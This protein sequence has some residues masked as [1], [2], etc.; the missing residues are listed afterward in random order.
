VLAIAA[1][2]GASY[3]VG[4]VLGLALR[5]P[6]STPSVLWPPNAILTAALLL[7]P[8]RHWLV[9][10]LAALPPHLLTESGTEDW[11]FRMI[12]GFYVTNCSQAVISAIGMRLFSHAPDR[13]DTTRQFAIFVSAV[14]IAAPLLSSFADAAV[15]HWWRGDPYWPVWQARTFSS[16]LGAVALTPAILAI[17]TDA[18]KFV[19]ESP[20]RP[21]VEA[22]LIGFAL[23]I[24]GALLLGHP[25][26][27]NWLNVISERQPL[28]LLLPI[29]VWATL[30]FGSHGASLTLFLSTL[31]MVTMAAKAR[32]PFAAVSGNSAV[33][34]LQLSLISVSIPLLGLAVVI[35]ER[36]EAQRTLS[37]QLSFEQMLSR[38]SREFVRLPSE[39]MESALG[40]WLKHLGEFLRIERVVLFRVAD[41]SRE[42]DR[43]AEWV[44]PGLTPSTE[45][46]PSRDFPWTVDRVLSG[47]TVVLG[48]RR[49][50]PAEAAIDAASCATYGC[51]SLV[52]LPLMAGSKVVGAMAF[53]SVRSTVA[54]SDAAVGRLQLVAEVFANALTRKRKD[55]A[56]RGTKLVHGAILSSITAGVAVVSREGRVLLINNTWN[57]STGD[58]GLPGQPAEIGAVFLQ[59]YREAA[60]RG[61]PA[62]REIVAGIEAVLAGASPRF[63]HQYTSPDGRWSV[64]TARP[65]NR[66][67]GG[68]VLTHND[69][70]ERKRAELD[71]QRVR[72]ELA[73]FTRVSTMGELTA[74]LAHQLN[75]PLTGILSNAQA[76]V[77]LLDRQPAET[78]EVRAILTDIIADDRRAAEVIVRMHELLRKSEPD[79]VP[80]DLNDLARG[81]ARLVAS[82]ALIRNVA[83]TMHLEPA[84]LVVR[85]DRVQLQQVVLNLLINSLEALA[86][87]QNIER[88]VSLHSWRG[89]GRAHVSVSDSGQGFDR[90]TE[91]RAFEPFYTTK[92][93]G[94]GMGLSIAR[95]IIEAHGG[96]IH[97]ASTARGA[98]V[99]F[100]LPVESRLE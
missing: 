74:S 22:S 81:V 62:A 54:W 69:I 7:T 11:S 72:G 32:G 56:L 21:I 82:D 51:R 41:G 59:P 89:A 36:A 5:L 80:L 38:L 15:A 70:T 92:P 40:V 64:F 57:R 53:G 24:V 88:R 93:T 25:I 12:V 34:S 87:R 77:R 66:P 58:S 3:Y 39:E 30:R 8:P 28:V 71:A 14:V 55:D 68:L 79:V 19:A 84:P 45:L 4:A 96:A 86:D 31:L 26:R 48:N 29:L 52:A 85:G 78:T 98:V 37:R 63:E 47:S 73:H 44:A 18:P 10:L 97:A 46:I 9:Y 2:V 99:E 20:P 17:V 33:I 49:D 65:L 61:Q 16:I 1:L 67:D 50:L 13:L 42:L 90:G 75:Q 76:A 83:M 94:M 23:L 100:T 43:I 95:S 35:K 60:A 91:G 6:G 27:T